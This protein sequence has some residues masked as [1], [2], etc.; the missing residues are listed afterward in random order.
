MENKNMK[1]NKEQGQEIVNINTY[2]KINS[3]ISII[4]LNMKS[5]YTN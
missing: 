1:R 4:T 3:A 5:K 2:G